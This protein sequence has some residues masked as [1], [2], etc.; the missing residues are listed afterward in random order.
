M[1]KLNIGEVVEITGFI[2]IEK[3]SYRSS[4]KLVEKT[5]K[6]PRKVLLLGKSKRSA[7][8]MQY[9]DWDDPGVFM[10]EAV[11]DVWIVMEIN[12]HNCFR[13]P[14]AVFENQI[15]VGD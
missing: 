4:T 6:E 11:Y 9:S 3:P 15:L 10:T 8:N 1:S 14:L 5:Y 7:G 2:V 12:K 13:T